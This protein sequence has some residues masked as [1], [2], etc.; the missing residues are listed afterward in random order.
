MLKFIGD[1]PTLQKLQLL[2]GH[3]GRRLKVIE[4]VA[5]RWEELASALQ[6]DHLVIL[7]VKADYLHREVAACRHIF[8]MW[9]EEERD[10][11]RSPVTWETFIQCLTD[12]EFSHISVELEEILSSQ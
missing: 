2:K 4:E 12:A 1:K 11:L 6:F 5:P 10:H 7:Q 8:T 9:L 3:N